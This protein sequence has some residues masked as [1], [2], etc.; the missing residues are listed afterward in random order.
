LY[1]EG[2][3]VY[4]LVLEYPYKLDEDGEVTPQALLL[5]DKLYE[6]IFEGQMILIFD[7]NKRLMGST[8]A[9]PT[10]I[11]LK[12]GEYLLR[13]Q[14]RHDDTS[15]LEKLKTMPLSIDRKLEKAISLKAYVSYNGALASQGEFGELKVK[16]GVRAVVFFTIP[17]DEK[18]PDPVKQGD[19]L[20]GP[21]SYGEPSVPGAG[22][23][24]RGGWAVQ[25][26]VTAPKAEEKKTDEEDED[27]RLPQEKL[28]DAIRD[29]EIKHLEA[30]RK[31]ASKDEHD[32]LLDRL[33]KS[34]KKHLPLHLE[35]LKGLEEIKSPD[36]EQ[37][38]AGERTRLQQIVQAVDEMIEV[39]DLKELAS[40]L[41]RRVDPEDKKAVKAGKEWDKTKDAVIQGF[42]KK[43][44]ALAK[45]HKT[46]GMQEVDSKYKVVQSFKQLSQWADVSDTKHARAI[47]LYEQTVGHMGLALAALNKEI[48]EE[49]IPK[50]ELLEERAELLQ[51]LG[52]HTWADEERV[53]LCIKFPKLYSR[54]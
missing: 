15:M 24:N 27:Q 35:R 17:V 49:K 13:M 3:R 43:L 38:A 46:H 20:L 2:K 42:T 39:I 40:H 14:V 19:Q 5:N 7:S 44:V 29:A 4:E 8:D 30:L 23:K 9:W 32:A 18:L 1:L 22:K 6:S 28:R 48:G 47:M 37:A 26:A 12:K 41:G 53:S 36:A 16:G 34:H 52:W 25:Y 54:F 31:W 33:L 11:K 51:A 10:P 50:R 21:V 45:L